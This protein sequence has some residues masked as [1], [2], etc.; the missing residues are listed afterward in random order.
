MSM[1]RIETFP[2]GESLVGQS[3]WWGAPDLPE[4]VPYPSVTVCDDN[5][6]EYEEPL[7]FL[8]QIRC[9]DIA[10]L[11]SEG[12]LPHEGM[13]WF[14]APLDYFLGETG[15]PLDYHIPPVVLYRPSLEGLVPYDLHWEE[16]GESVFRP[17]EKIVFSQSGGLQGDGHGL[18]SIPYQDEVGDAHP[19]EIALLQVDEDERWGLRFYDCGMY[20]IMISPEDLRRGSW[21]KAHG[22]LFFY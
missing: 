22:E 10:A 21:G 9:S 15:S 17:A 11:D 6:E 19:G 20:Y 14:F 5:G 2:C 3:H 1:V 12:L 13:L 8:C 18:L 4:D 7:T 16:T